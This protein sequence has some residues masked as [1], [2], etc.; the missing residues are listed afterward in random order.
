MA[1][2]KV[3]DV[4]YELAVPIAEESQCE[5][6]DVVFKKEGSNW[7]L[8]VFIDKEDGVGLDDCERV[9]KAL[10]DVLDKVDPIPQS[11]YLEVSSPGIN[12]PLKKDRDFERSVGEKIEIK[13]Y[14][15]LDG[16]KILCGTLE[17]YQDGMIHIKT[18]DASVIE[19]NKADTALVRLG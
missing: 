6:V 1:K 7:F 12:R 10:S 2:G 11:Y 18:D 4:V 15:A 8:R 17:K 5:L 16:K 9:S 19:I 3:E 13:L 14:Q